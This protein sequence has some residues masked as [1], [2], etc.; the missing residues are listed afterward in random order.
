MVFTYYLFQLPNLSYAQ[1]T[2]LIGEDPKPANKQ[3][4]KVENISDEFDDTVLDESKW[5]NTNPNRWIG[6]PPGIFKK[7]VVS[8]KDGE[9]RMTNYQLDEPEIVN[10]NTFTHA[11]GNIYSRNA[12][13]VGYYYECR[14]KSS[15]TFMS[16]TFWLI[17]TRGEG[18]GCDRRVTELDIQE[19]VGQVTN[20]QNWAQS[21]DQSIH[22]NT[23]SRNTTCESTPI[24]SS[25]DNSPTVEKVWEDY[26]V[27]GCWWKSPRE[28]EFYLDGKKVYTVSPVADFDLP[29]Y[30]RLVSETYDWNPAPS[31][32]GMTGTEADRTTAYDW[33]RSWK[34]EDDNTTSTEE[35]G[36]NAI[37][38]YPNPT[39]S[40]LVTI[41]LGNEA[42]GATVNLFDS[43]GRLVYTDR[44]SKKEV[45]LSV[46]AFSEG[47]YMV[48]VQTKKGSQFGKLLVLR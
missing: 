20:T 2:F 36:T 40:G 22:S 12:G 45:V 29:M 35:Y 5:E 19:C 43:Y 30:L 15:K 31:D 16:S 42:V 37:K 7:D 25:G 34:L 4:V 3:W 11:G 28:V 23:H 9:L 27:Y 26:H 14:M 32:G 33:V 10:G 41:D 21:F 18:S 39:Q 46:A 44:A 13:Q 47:I 6:R 24:G 1:P 8:L 38:I 17:N 48:E